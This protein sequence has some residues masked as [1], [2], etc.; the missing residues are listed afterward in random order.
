MLSARLATSWA[1]KLLGGHSSANVPNS[2]LSA[3]RRGSFRPPTATTQAGDTIHN[4]I[5]V[6]GT[7]DPLRD[8]QT[9][10]QYAAGI[11][12][13]QAARRRKGLLG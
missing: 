7:G 10:M 13:E 4:H 11:E 5:T 3:P 12:A 8:R 9:G 2:M 1:S 6:K